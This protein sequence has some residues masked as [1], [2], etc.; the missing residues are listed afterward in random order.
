MTRYRKPLAVLVTVLALWTRLA[1]ADLSGVWTLSWEPDFGGN[2]D[3][4][5]CTFKQND[6]TLTVTCR[7]DPNATMTGDVD[8]QKVT[9]RFKT[10]R[11]GSQT[12]TLTG[13]LDRP[14]TT[15]IG[16]WHLSAPEN[17]DGKFVARKQ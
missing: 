11:D 8:Q 7:D 5:D 13:E 16:T 2:L 3:A 12:A 4:Y 6:R 10:G 9:L 1:A 15:I 14:G 17:R